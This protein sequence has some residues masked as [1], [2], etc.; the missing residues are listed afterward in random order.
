MQPL[1]KLVSD[2]IVVG[3]DVVVV[4][5]NDG[6]AVEMIVCLALNKGRA[7]GSH[8]RGPRAP[9]WVHQQQ[10]SGFLFMTPPIV[11]PGLVHL[12]RP[13]V[14]RTR[15]RPTAALPRPGLTPEQNWARFH[16]VE[17]SQEQIRDHRIGQ[18]RQSWLDAV[19]L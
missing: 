7:R 5:R 1:H 18:R 15:I 8:H 10:R 3:V 6:G 13:M 12:P 2:A 11:C 4:V 16:W 19:H 17:R 9:R 14:K